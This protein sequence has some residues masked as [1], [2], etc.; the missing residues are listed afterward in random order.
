MRTPPNTYVKKSG[1]YYFQLRVPTD[2]Q[3]QIKTAVI[4][5]SLATRSPREAGQRAS[6]LHSEYT[7][8]FAQLRKEAQETRSLSIEEA[9]VLASKYRQYIEDAA[10]N[11]TVN[12]PD[13]GGEWSVDARS[14]L[15]DVNQFSQFSRNLRLDEPAKELADAFVLKTIEDMQNES[16]AT[17]KIKHVKAKATPMPTG[18]RKSVESL[19]DLLIA[20]KK[21]TT[22]RCKVYQKT[23]AAL[24]DY[25]GRKARIDDLDKETMR[26]FRDHQLQSLKPSSWSNYAAIWH[27]LINLAVDED[28]IAKP[29]KV[30]I[31]P[32]ELK[33][34]KREQGL[35]LYDSGGQRR[36]A[37]EGEIKTMVKWFPSHRDYVTLLALTGMRSAEAAQL[38][39]SDVVATPKSGLMVRISDTKGR[40]VKN[41][42]SVR[43]VPIPRCMEGYVR[44]RMESGDL[45]LFDIDMLKFRREFSLK[46]RKVLD[47]NV[48]LHSLRHTFKAVCRN[49]GVSSDL[50]NYITG[51]TSGTNKT[52][53]DYGEGFAQA[54]EVLRA[55]I[56]QVEGRMGQWLAMDE[57][58]TA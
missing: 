14:V 5:K 9:E 11:L 1:V 36:A 21:P 3:P 37:T 38:L 40:S 16:P 23:V 31:T 55:V 30:S 33:A 39:V 52:A 41:K 7:S 2:L 45:T 28:L 10:Q 19:L 24:D 58:T 35:P 48:T 56:E 29:F 27:M 8:L 57:T 34:L 15:I 18:R 25:L 13:M 49:L 54:Y 32:D 12:V 43:T 51:H 26:A 20:T 53:M 46:K 22:T 17:A 50:N 4:R 47:D 6:Q 44:S 42:S